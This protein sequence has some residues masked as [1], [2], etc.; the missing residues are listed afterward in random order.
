MEKS[1]YYKVNLLEA[2]MYAD[3]LV[4]FGIPYQIKQIAAGQL[5]IVFPDLPI[6]QFNFVQKLFNGIGEV[7]P[8]HLKDKSI[9]RMPLPAFDE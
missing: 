2:N 8:R 7:Y 4:G 1:F 3:L 6:R 5:A 9:Y